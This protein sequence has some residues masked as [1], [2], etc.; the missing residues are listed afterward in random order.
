GTTLNAGRDG[1]PGYGGTL[2]LTG[3]HLVL[4]GQVTMSIPLG[5]ITETAL[6]GERLLLTLRNGEGLTLDVGQPRLLRAELAAVR[7]LSR[8]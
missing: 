3:T 6:A 8:P 5:D 4:A 1:M 2:Y 7:H